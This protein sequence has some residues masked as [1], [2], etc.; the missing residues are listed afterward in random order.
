MLD[1][2][3]KDT[4]YAVLNDLVVRSPH[5][6]GVS[7]IGAFHDSVF[8]GSYYAD[9]VIVATPTGSTAYSLSAGGAVLD[10]TLSCIS[11]TPV[12]PVGRRNPSLVFSAD[13]TLRLRNLS[14]KGTSVCLVA[15]GE[16]IGSLL[17][18]EEVCVTRSQKTACFLHLKQ[19]SFC[20]TLR[21][22]VLA[23]E[24]QKRLSLWE[25]NV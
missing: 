22:K 14:R 5:A 20:N 21:N 11:L 3:T 12:C 15:D 16:D 23:D 18:E 19:D 17:P 24:A 1:V 8:I 2:K 9:G 6:A 7:R 13:S 25:E 10:P 4:T